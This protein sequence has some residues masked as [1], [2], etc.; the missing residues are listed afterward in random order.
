MGLR[1]FFGRYLPVC[2]VAF[3]GLARGMETLSGVAK[4]ALVDSMEQALCA[5][6][7]SFN[8]QTP[9]RF[10]KAYNDWKIDESIRMLQ[11]MKLRPVDPYKAISGMH[12]YY[13]VAKRISGG[14]HD[15]AVRQ[16]EDRYDGFQ[17][18]MTMMQMMQYI[19]ALEDRVERLEQI[20]S[21]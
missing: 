21:A 8:E 14:N 16:L 4:E 15:R 3:P 19:S 7:V 20:L 1:N 10:F 11:I 18:T 5:D 9:E 2:H 12:K 17:H 13:E 6:M